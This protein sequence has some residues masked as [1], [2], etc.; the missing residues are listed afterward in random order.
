MTWSGGVSVAGTAV[1][2][3][4]AGAPVV[5]PAV[6][7]ELEPGAAHA[8]SIAM[9]HRRTAARS[10]VTGRER[11][12]LFANAVRRASAA[13][14]LAVETLGSSRAMPSPDAIDRLLLQDDELPR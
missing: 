12:K 10:R 4:V 7:A 3:V 8:A 11:I 6:G 5:G 14:S 2:P 1:G 13:G 9:T